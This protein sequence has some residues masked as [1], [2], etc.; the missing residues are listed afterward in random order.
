MERCLRVLIKTVTASDVWFKDLT[1]AATYWTSL[2][3]K[4]EEHSESNVC[5]PWKRFQRA[6]LSRGRKGGR[7]HIRKILKRKQKGGGWSP[8]LW[9]GGLVGYQGRL[10]GQMKV[11]TGV[12]KMSLDFKYSF[13]GICETSVDKVREAMW[14]GSSRQR[15][16]LKTTMCQSSP[17]I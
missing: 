4:Q 1:L 3:W 16:G 7:K 6:E 12:K 5:R 10:P 13:Q 15:P 11:K 2:G 17:D 9:L 8:G 14:G